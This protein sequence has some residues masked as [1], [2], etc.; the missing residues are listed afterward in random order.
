MIIKPLSAGGRICTTFA[1]MAAARSRI[2][3]L[4]LS[5]PAPYPIPDFAFTSPSAV[6]NSTASSS[7][8]N[9]RR[10]CSGATRAGR[11]S[12]SAAASETTIEPSRTTAKSRL[13]NIAAPSSSVGTL[14][15]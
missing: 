12:S 11:F 15:L 1:P 5:S 8:V 13:M 3:L 2:V 9:V 14:P 10:T 6:Q 7:D 4:T